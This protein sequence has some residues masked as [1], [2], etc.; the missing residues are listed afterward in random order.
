MSKQQQKYEIVGIHPRDAYSRPPMPN[1][2]G[3]TGTT[4]SDYEEHI[5]GYYCGCFK[6][7]KKFREKFTNKGRYNHPFF[8]AVKLKAIKAKKK[9]AKNVPLE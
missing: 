8:Y 2:I 7:D 6:I 1:L 9:G 3:I 5:K 4:E